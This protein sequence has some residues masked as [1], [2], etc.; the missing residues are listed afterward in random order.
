M[1]FD[2]TEF[3]KYGTPPNWN[4]TLE[5]DAWNSRK[6]NRCF[7]NIDTAKNQPFLECIWNKTAWQEGWLCC[8]CLEDHP[9]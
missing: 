1:S 7:V 4:K 9:S 8:P 6:P 3:D 2:F 5:N